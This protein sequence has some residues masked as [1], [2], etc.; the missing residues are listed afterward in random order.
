MMAD[1]RFNFFAEGYGKDVLFFESLLSTNDYC[2]NE[3]SLPGELVV[4]AKSQS[5]GKGRLSRVWKDLPGASLS[6]SL[7]IKPA[8]IINMR[9]L[10]FVCG[11]SLRAALS[12][13]AGISVGLKWVNDVVYGG[14]KLA[15]I[16]CESRISG[17]EAA[18]ICGFGLN[19]NQDQEYFDKNGLKFA[20]SLKL[21]TGRNFDILETA[22]AILEKFNIYYNIYQRSGF[23]PLC[24]EYNR[25]CVNIGREAVF[26]KDGKETR[27]TALLVLENGNLLV[28]AGGGDIALESGEVS[29]RG[30]GTYY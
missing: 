20:S 28:R 23:A 18:A 30:A 26:Q 3:A 12:D 22:K 21:L 25:H 2:K 10:P 27:G 13:F 17:G 19:L 8:N 6:M 4:I 5:A 1:G 15:G 24:G 14:G 29:V 7:L 9:Q 11:L 16:L